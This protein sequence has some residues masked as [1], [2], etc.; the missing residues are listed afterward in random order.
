MWLEFTSCRK[1]KKYSLTDYTSYIIIDVAE[2]KGIHRQTCFVHTSWFSSSST[3]SEM[4]WPFLQRNS[5]FSEI[6]MLW[7][8]TSGR[9]QNFFTECGSSVSVISFPGYFA[10]KASTSSSSMLMKA[11]TLLLLRFSMFIFMLVLPIALWVCLLSLKHKMVICMDEGGA[12]LE[13]LTYAKCRRSLHKRVH[14]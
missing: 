10:I 9:K 13:K 5:V 12:A 11:R 6:K 4:Y 1:F 14:Q 7:L 8:S 3:K 2:D